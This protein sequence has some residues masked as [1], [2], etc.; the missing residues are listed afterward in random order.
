[1]DGLNIVSITNTAYDQHIDNIND[2]AYCDHFYN[3]PSNPD[4]D[5]ASALNQRAEISKMMG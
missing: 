2:N 3:T 5:F 1:M 4:S